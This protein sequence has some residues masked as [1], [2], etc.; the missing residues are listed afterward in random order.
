MIHQQYNHTYSEFYSFAH[1][2]CAALKRFRTHF[3]DFLCI[4][5]IVLQGIE[6]ELLQDTNLKWNKEVTRLPACLPALPS[7]RTCVSRGDCF[8]GEAGTSSLREAFS[9]LRESVCCRSLL[10]VQAQRLSFPFSSSCSELSCCFSSWE[11]QQT[12]SAF[13]CITA[14]VASSVPAPHLDLLSLPLVRYG[15]G[16]R[17]VPLEY[18]PFLL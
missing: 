2:W 11:G 5:K 9:C 1:G 10:C 17:C 6:A 16:G 15:S 8:K 14:H 4:G 13:T 3:M 12:D 7:F 18:S